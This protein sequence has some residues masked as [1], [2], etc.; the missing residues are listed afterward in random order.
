MTRSSDR[1]APL[2]GLWTHL[3]DG[4]FH[5]SQF[6]TLPA[7][8]DHCDAHFKLGPTAGEVKDLAGDQ[9]SL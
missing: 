2:N 6:A 9:K 3:K 7:V 4:F 1:T 8:I 5:D